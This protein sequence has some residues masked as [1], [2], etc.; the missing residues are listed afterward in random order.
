M[1]SGKMTG[2]TWRFT[3]REQNNTDATRFARV[4]EMR[5]TVFY[6]FEEILGGFLS[7][8]LDFF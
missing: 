5:N 4:F 3:A 1:A 6:K 2:I 7:A 8:S